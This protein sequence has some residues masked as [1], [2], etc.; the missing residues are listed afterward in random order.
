[1]LKR[2]NWVT[3]IRVLELGY[4]SGG[5][6]RSTAYFLP[7]RCFPVPIVSGYR[8]FVISVLFAIGG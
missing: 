6:N 2:L 8:I 7:D 1:M 4:R 3:L 5:L